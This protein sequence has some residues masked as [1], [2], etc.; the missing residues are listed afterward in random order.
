MSAI[1]ILS[2]GLMVVVGLSAAAG[3]SAP[4]GKAGPADDMKALKGTW[5]GKAVTFDGDDVGADV[6]DKLHFTFDGDKLTQRGGLAKAGNKYL[7]IARRDTYKVTL[8]TNDKLKTIDLKVDKEGGRTIPGIYK[9]EKGK[10]TI[11]LNYKNTERPT[12]FKSEADSGVGV[13]E[14]EKKDK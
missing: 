14:C 1:R 4:A 10:L 5:V 7:P 9:L 8:G 11:V 2:A 12:E 13:F 3:Q 6:A